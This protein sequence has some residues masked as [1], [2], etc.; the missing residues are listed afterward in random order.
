MVSWN[1]G[2]L[3]KQPSVAGYWN[4]EQPA[5]CGAAVSDGRSKL[6]WSVHI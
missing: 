5:N 3:E 6:Q 4:I 1:C 2:N